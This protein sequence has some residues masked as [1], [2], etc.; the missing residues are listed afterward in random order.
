SSAVFRMVFNVW[1]FHL[2]FNIL[3]NAVGSDQDVNSVR[4]LHITDSHIS[5]SNEAPP[6]S[7][8]MHAAFSRSKHHET[9]ISTT[10][11]Q[12]FAKL[13]AMAKDINADVVVLGGDIL[14]FPSNSTATW[15]LEQLNL[16]GCG[17][18]FTA[19]NHDWHLEGQRGAAS[20]D[21]ARVPELFSTFRPFFEQSLSSRGSCYDALGH[22]SSEGLGF[23]YGCAL[24]KGLLLLFVDNS[25]FQV[26]DDQLEFTRLQLASAAGRRMPV[27]V[28]LHIPLQLPGLTLP[29]KELCGHQQWGS[30]TDALWQVEDRPR[31]PPANRP[32]TLAFRELLRAHAAPMGPIAALLS[33]HTH[34][35]AA[36]ALGES[37]SESCTATSACWTVESRTGQ[38]P[39]SQVSDALQYTTRAAAEGAYRILTISS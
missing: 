29:P 30:D 21:A 20:Y 26:D 13:V 7:S 11:A 10:P 33:G 24:V 28:L 12:E 32:S 8:R 14:N 22:W 38:E 18:I 39:P 1:S 31:W 6:R 25:N 35:E 27:V 19:G 37:D 5:L 15:V 23:L 2:I 16:A 4:L 3:C 17:F 9:K 34:E 36:V